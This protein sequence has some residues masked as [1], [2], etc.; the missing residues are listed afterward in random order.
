[1][2]LDFCCTIHDEAVVVQV[3]LCVGKQICCCEDYE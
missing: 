3:A 1:M 2:H